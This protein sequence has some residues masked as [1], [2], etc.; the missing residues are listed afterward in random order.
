MPEAEIRKENDRTH[1]IDY[2]T[3]DAVPLH[4][5][6][7]CSNLIDGGMQCGIYDLDL[8]RATVYFAVFFQPGEGF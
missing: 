7:L 4:G 5:R 3:Q 8:F 2:V 1:N 6:C